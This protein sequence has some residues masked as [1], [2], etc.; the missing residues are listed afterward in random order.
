MSANFGRVRP[1]SCQ[2]IGEHKSSSV[3]IGH[4]S[5]AVRANRSR[6][7]LGR[8]VSG[9]DTSGAGPERFR[10]AERSCV[11]RSI[12]L[13]DGCARTFGPTG[14][15]PPQARHE[16]PL[17]DVERHRLLEEG[18]ASLDPELARR[19]P[20]EGARVCEREAHRLRRIL[21]NGWG[22]M[23]ERCWVADPRSAHPSPHTRKR[24]QPEAVGGRP[25][26]LR[27][28]ARTSA[29]IRQT[30]ARLCCQARAPRSARG[31]CSRLLRPLSGR[32]NAR[33]ANLA[34]ELA[35]QL[36]IRACQARR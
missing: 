15:L 12:S 11:T 10:A 25:Q 4:N 26:P 3:H 29:Q 19:R 23:R 14:D 24:T 22:P 35:S 6:A 33:P 5:A 18:V 7:A 20:L 30:S 9:T 36:A 1:K 28:V 2:I 21:A 34:L 17:H 27:D 31:A 8:Q 13:L 16:E 32:H